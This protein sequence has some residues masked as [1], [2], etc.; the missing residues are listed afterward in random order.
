MLCDSGI[1][2]YIFI[3]FFFISGCYICIISDLYV[4]VF[5][6][7]RLLSAVTKVFSIDLFILE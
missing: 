1:S 7:F 2:S 4:F 5:L 6:N 3:Y